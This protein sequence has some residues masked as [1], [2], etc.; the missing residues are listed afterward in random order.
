MER[1][2]EEQRERRETEI[3]QKGQGSKKEG[4]RLFV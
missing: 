4:Q 2:R 3:Y 1:K